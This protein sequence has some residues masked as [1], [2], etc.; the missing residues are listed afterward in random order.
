MDFFPN[1][2]KGKRIL[3]EEACSTHDCGNENLR[4][5]S[6]LRTILANGRERFAAIWC[7][8]GYLKSR[9]M[10]GSDL[11]LPSS[12]SHVKTNQ[13]NEVSQVFCSPFK[14]YICFLWGGF[15][16]TPKKQNGPGDAKWN[17]KSPDHPYHGF[18]GS[19]N[20]KVR[21]MGGCI[22]NWAWIF[23]RSQS[24][25]RGRA[26]ATRGSEAY[27]AG[28]AKKAVGRFFVWTYK[29]NDMEV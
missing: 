14:L 15:G 1:F 27:S 21:Q 16:R 10:I 17:K 26:T 7:E 24:N 23:L 28:A 29:T 12:H 20:G 22:G 18:L 11:E 3:G 25:C 5:I 2:L 6:N 9:A 4:E 8:H 19:H 13:Y